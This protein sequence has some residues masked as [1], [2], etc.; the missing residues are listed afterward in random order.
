MNVFVYDRLFN[1][2]YASEGPVRFMYLDKLGLVTVG[3]GFMIDP[4]DKY[5]GEW[6]NS[7]KK[8]DGTPASPDEVTA[9]FN[10]VKSMQTQKGAW[11]NFEPDAELFLPAPAMKPT[12]LK[13]LR[14]K[15]NALQTDWRKQFFEKFDSF[16]PDAQMGV[17]STAYGGM[18]N[19]TPAQIAFNTACKNQEWATAAESGRW[20]GLGAAKNRGPQIDV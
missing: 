7:F 3:I 4:I 17:L 10:R 20:D 6:G 8:K 9:E 5:I 15:E 18:Y 2:L 19:S 12:V 11:K 13:I 1:W 16:P 14:Q